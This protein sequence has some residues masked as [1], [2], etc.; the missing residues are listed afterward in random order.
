MAK[1]KAKC[2]K[3]N[4]T[5]IGPKVERYDGCFEICSRCNG[6]GAETIE[7]SPFIVRIERNDVKEVRV[8]K[9]SGVLCNYGSE[10]KIVSY[11]EFLKIKNWPEYLYKIR[12]KYAADS[13]I[14]FPD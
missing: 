10:D 2:S 14:D 9:A 8:K 4:G 5:G 7:Y 11:K 1:I 3:C 12:K 6:T 13:T